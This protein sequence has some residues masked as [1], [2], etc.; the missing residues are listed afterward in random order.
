MKSKGSNPSV[1]N[2]VKFCG[3]GESCAN[4]CERGIND[5]AEKDFL[6]AE[7]NRFRSLVAAGKMKGRNNRPLPPAQDM[8]ELVWDDELAYLAQMQQI[9]TMNV[10]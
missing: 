2:A 3:L 9:L 8:R 4:F 6:V 7:H 10:P 5:Q 1:H